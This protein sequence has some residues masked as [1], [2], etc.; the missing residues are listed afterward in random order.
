MKVDNT[1][2]SVTGIVYTNGKANTGD[3]DLSNLSTYTYVD[4]TF[5]KKSGGTLTGE[6]IVNNVLSVLSGTITNKTSGT[7]V[8]YSLPTSKGRCMIIEYTIYNNGNTSSRSGNVTCNFNTTGITYKE[9]ATP[10]LGTSTS[11]VKFVP[12]I[13]GSNVLFQSIITGSDTWNFKLSIRYF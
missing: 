5:L 6:L 2:V 8:L 13:S 4:G 11:S 3:Q 1:G 10:D 7:H 12:I 9:D